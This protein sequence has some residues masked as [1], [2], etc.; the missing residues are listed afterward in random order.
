[1]DLPEQLPK[2]VAAILLW[3]PH[4]F[5]LDVAM[6][7]AASALRDLDTPTNVPML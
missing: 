1:M 2:V 4:V 5:L 6:N 3:R 7:A